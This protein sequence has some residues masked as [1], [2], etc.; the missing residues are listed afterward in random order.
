M[1]W[2]QKSGARGGQRQ[3]IPEGETSLLREFSD[4]DYLDNF[5]ATKF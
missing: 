1:H 4:D 3:A 2:L 5:A